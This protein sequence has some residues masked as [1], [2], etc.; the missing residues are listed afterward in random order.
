MLIW[1]S[2]DR[3]PFPCHGRCNSVSTTFA[4]Q[5]LVFRR[6]VSLGPAFGARVSANILAS[7]SSASS[8]LAL[9]ALVSAIALQS[10]GDSLVSGVVATEVVSRCQV[11][12]IPAEAN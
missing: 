7:G 4:V 1:K 6:S 10:F 12:L 9:V 2:G 8:A 11:G 3:S 5:V